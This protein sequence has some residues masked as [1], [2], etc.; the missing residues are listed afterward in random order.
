MREKSLNKRA[1][2]PKHR[3]WTDIIVLSKYQNVLVL[4]LQFNIWHFTPQKLTVLCTMMTT[5]RTMWNAG[6]M[7]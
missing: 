4:E 7:N 2:G 3:Q 5:P 6:A 1:S